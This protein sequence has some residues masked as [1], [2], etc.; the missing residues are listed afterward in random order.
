MRNGTEVNAEGSESTVRGGSLD[1]MSI[2]VAGLGHLG[3]GDHRVTTG[4]HSVQHLWDTCSD[5]ASN[6]GV[7]T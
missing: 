2:S 5:C 4:L 6:S 7:C 3:T 1:N